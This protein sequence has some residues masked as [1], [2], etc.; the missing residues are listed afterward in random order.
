MLKPTYPSRLLI[1]LAVAA[2]L[3]LPVGPAFALSS[4]DY[5][6]K[7]A[8]EI[9]KS[10]EQQGYKVNEIESEDDLLEAKADIDGKPYEI[11][12]DPRT[13]KIV[14]IKEDN[15]DNDGSIIKR[16]IKAVWNWW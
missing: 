2:V 9:T 10:L 14:E 8:A 11:Y 13:G 6:G 15:G 1:C 12:T 4:G 7:T 16:M 5:V 3:A